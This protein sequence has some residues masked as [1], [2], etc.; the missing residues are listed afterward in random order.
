[1][2]LDKFFFIK[3][4]FFFSASAGGR[5][6]SVGVQHINPTRRERAIGFPSQGQPGFAQLLESCGPHTGDDFPDFE[7]QPVVDFF[8]R[9]PPP[10]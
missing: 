9:R 8:Q 5:E 6:F 1:M 10:H 2:W 7:R 4:I 3:S